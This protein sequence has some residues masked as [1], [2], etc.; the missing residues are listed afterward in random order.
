LEL[1]C[2]LGSIDIEMVVKRLA[3]FRKNE[4]G[5][6]HGYIIKYNIYAEN[7]RVK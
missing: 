1:E 4:T 2:R 3:G 6:K 5:R 7:K